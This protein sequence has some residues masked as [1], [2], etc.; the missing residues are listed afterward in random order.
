V[1]LAAHF[2]S[3]AV[4]A[5][6]TTS[7]TGNLI[8]NLTPVVMPLAMWVLNR[9]RINRGEV[10]G[11][12][13]A[14]I[15][16]VALL[17][18]HMFGHES[19][20]GDLVCFLSMALFCCYLAFSRRNAGGRSLWPYL[21][22]L[23]WIAGVICVVIALLAR[24]PL[25]QWTP[26][27][28]TMLLCLCLVPTVMGHSIINHSIRIMRGQ[29]VGI[30]NLSQFIFA[31]VIGYLFFAELPAWTFYPV[32][33]LIVTGALIVIRAHRTTVDVDAES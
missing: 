14:M 18:T 21:V 11:T 15:G 5:R 9:E 30:V 6:M 31:G 32:C 19:V 33:A 27:E 17:I 29:T 8:V 4:G 24:A 13:I 16:V 26:L 12:S 20:W 3:W 28:I 10:L 22:P 1:L 23:Y 25:P 7:A 2:A